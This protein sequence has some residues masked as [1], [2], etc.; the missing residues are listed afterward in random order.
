[1]GAFEDL[2]KKF[3]QEENSKDNLHEEILE[4]VR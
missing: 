4:L 1:M 3:A 2:N